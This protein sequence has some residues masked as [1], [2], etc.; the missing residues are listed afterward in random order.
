MTKKEWEK[1]WND[2]DIQ[3]DKIDDKFQ[4]EM[5]KKHGNGHYY[6][7]PDEHWV[8]QQK[9]IRKLVEAKLKEKNT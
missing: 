9:I 4:K 1:F 7:N 8:R 6:I 3:T 5:I 2:F